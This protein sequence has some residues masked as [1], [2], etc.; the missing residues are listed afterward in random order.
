MFDEDVKRF[1]AMHHPQ[2]AGDDF[3]RRLTA[4]T[5]RAAKNRAGCTRE[6]KGSVWIFLLMTDDNSENKQS[7][8]Q[9]KD[10]ASRRRIVQALFFVFG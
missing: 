4:K 8:K 6:K 2:H 10:A 7:Y 9:S 1:G 5:R 3:V